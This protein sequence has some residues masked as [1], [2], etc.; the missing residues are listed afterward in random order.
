MFFCK[1]L[2]SM[3][4]MD[5]RSRIADIIITVPWPIGLM[6]AAAHARRR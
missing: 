4:S 2:A 1:L 5:S 3:D 6:G